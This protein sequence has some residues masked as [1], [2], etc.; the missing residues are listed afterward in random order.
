MY[1]G[2]N[3]WNQWGYHLE[4]EMGRATQIRSEAHGFHRG[5]KFRLAGQIISLKMAMELL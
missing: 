2:R 3:L 5:N 1:L 4:D